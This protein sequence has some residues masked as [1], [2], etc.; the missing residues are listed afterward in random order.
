MASG[1]QTVLVSRWR[2]GGQTNLN[3]VREFLQELGKVPAS[4]AWYRATL[5]ARSMPLD[6]SSEPR[7]KPADVDAAQQPTADHPFFWAG[8][9]LV[10][11]GRNPTAADDEDAPPEDDPPVVKIK[12][13][14]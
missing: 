6:A 5:V 4:E 3:L 11:T 13:A 10:D 12:P 9:L 8:Y 7:M 1:A 2:T 14:D